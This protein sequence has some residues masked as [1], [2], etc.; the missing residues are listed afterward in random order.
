[1]VSGLIQHKR[2][3]GIRRAVVKLPQKVGMDY[4][5]RVWS[6]GLR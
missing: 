4:L 3:V 5:L 6:F 1:M 2:V